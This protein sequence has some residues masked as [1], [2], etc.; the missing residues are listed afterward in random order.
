[1]GDVQRKEAVIKSTKK[2]LHQQWRDYRTMLEPGS[3]ALPGDILGS[4][5]EVAASGTSGDGKAGVV[6][7]GPG[8]RQ[9]QDNVMV[10]KAGLVRHRDPCR[11]W[12]EAP[13]QHRYVANMGEEV[14]GIVTDKAGD[15]YKVDIG[16]S[17]KAWLSYLDFEGAT[18]RN[19]PNVKVG[20][21]LY[22]RLS[23]AN[24]DMQPEV[25]CVNQLGKANGLGKLENGFM[26]ESSLGHV[27]RLLTPDCAVLQLLAKRFKFEAAFGLNG[28]V[29]ARGTTLE[30]TIIITNT[31]IASEM[32]RPRQIERMID[33]L[34]GQ[35]R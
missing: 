21:L 25:T 15:V 27:R 10:M 13:H 32:M 11:F 4:L 33:S 28:R 23:L 34:A 22:C 20:D 16:T 29:W 8:L 2:D 24:R 30:Q 1:M 14:I 6:R 17:S 9:N 12:M 31:I 18:K 7:L 26:V 19:R 35:L 5:E 3:V